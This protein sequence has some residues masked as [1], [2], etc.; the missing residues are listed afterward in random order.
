LPSTITVAAL[1]LLP[2]PIE[3]AVLSAG[4]PAVADCVRVPP[5]KLFAAA[6]SVA[7]PFTPTSV[8]VSEPPDVVGVSAIASPDSA[9][10]RLDAS[11][12]TLPSPDTMA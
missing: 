1:T 3:A 8:E 6:P 11:W 9:A 12:M 10:A 5:G 7:E 2:A 4:L